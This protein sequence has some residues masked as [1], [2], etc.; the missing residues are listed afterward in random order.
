MQTNNE[1][2][3]AKFDVLSTNIEGEKSYTL[4]K[5]VPFMRL[6][7]Q[8]DNRWLAYCL[9]E[10]LMVNRVVKYTCPQTDGQRCNLSYTTSSLQ[11]FIENGYF[12]LKDEEWKD[13]VTGKKL[14]VKCARIDIPCCKMC[15]PHSEISLVS[16]CS[17][18]SKK[19]ATYGAIQWRCGCKGRAYYVGRNGLFKNGW[20]KFG[21]LIDNATNT[22]A[23]SSMSAADKG[24]LFKAP[25]SFFTD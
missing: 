25:T 1:M 21:P 7:P 5:K 10:K 3:E 18:A 15:Y 23:G 2:E 24:G 13:P 22:A 12:D 17:E 8:P 16:F 6:M 14:M 9:C 20:K 11:F 4:G 19:Y